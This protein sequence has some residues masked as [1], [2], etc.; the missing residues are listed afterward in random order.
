[1]H[2]NYNITKISYQVI[3]ISLAQT[4]LHNS[5]LM[6]ENNTQYPQCMKCSARLGKKTS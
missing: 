5:Y 4:F 3:K 6:Q 2:N 1:L